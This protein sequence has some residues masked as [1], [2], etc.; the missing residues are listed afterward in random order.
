MKTVFTLQEINSH[1]LLTLKY[2]YH[3]LVKKRTDKN[4]NNR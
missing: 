4:H 3:G 2:K 1:E